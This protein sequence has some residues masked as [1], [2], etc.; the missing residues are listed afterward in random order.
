MLKILG[1]SFIFRYK[2]LKNSGILYFLLSTSGVNLVFNPIVFFEY[3]NLLIL[4]NKID[5]NFLDQEWPS[6]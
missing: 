5:S 3:T 4:L 6:P 2:W 1:Q